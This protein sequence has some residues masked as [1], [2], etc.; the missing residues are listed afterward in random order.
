MAARWFPVGKDI[1]IVVDPRISAG[2]PVIFGRGVSIE[3]IRKRF[4]ARHRIEFIARDLALEP[5]VVETALQYAEQI[6]A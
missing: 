2:I 3:A 5:D 1:P 4:K 6:A